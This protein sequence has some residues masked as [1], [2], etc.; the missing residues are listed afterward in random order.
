MRLKKD[1]SHMRD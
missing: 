1:I